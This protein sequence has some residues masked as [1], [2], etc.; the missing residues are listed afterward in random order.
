AIN[1]SFTSEGT[2]TFENLRNSPNLK[3]NSTSPLYYDINSSLS[4]EEPIPL[5]PPDNLLDSWDKN[6]NYEQ[7]AATDLPILYAE[8]DSGE[9]S[10]SSVSY[11][12]KIKK[13]VSCETLGRT[14]LVKHQI[15][16]GDVLPIKKYPY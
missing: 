13:K 4:T 15:N 14:T 3:S 6:S 7:K 5:L 16:I 1:V 10:D 12:Q 8:L 11:S 2:V 9:F